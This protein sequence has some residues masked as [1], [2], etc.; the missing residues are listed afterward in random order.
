MAVLS[1]GCTP[2]LAQPAEAQS[3]KK[4]PGRPAPV[5]RFDGEDFYLVQ[6]E[7]RPGARTLA[8]LKDGDTP[9]KCS[10]R[11]WIRKVACKDLRAYEK[12]YTA[13]WDQAQRDVTYRS[14]TRLI[15]SGWTQQG[16][17]LQYRMMVWE[18]QGGALM[19]C[20]FELLSRPPAQQAAA[21]TELV[22]LQR[23]HWAQELKALFKQAPKLMANSFP[24]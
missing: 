1:C 6:Q 13:N 18:Q 5:L 17:L 3:S 2:G 23:L 22:N 7:S 4:V 21:M 11:L 9:E 20:E 12:A 10:R 14:D 19:A 24:R 15:H 16:E 8:F